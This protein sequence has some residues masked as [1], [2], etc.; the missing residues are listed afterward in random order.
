MSGLP[1]I[2]LVERV[3]ASLRQAS[4]YAQHGDMDH[5]KGE[6]RET[7]RWLDQLREAVQG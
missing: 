7:K 6:L 2:V 4:M 5:V 3:A 1:E